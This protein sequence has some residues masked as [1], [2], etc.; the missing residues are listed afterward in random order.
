MKTHASIGAKILQSSD[1]P[2]LI[3]GEEIARCHHE[4]WDGR[5]YP[6]GLKGEEIPLA[7]RLMNIS[8]QYDALRS[9]RPYKPALDHEVVFDIIAK[10]DG[11][12]MPEHFDPRVLEAFS[13][14]AAKFRDV[15]ETHKEDIVATKW[16]Q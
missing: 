10:G 7:A 6:G 4:R 11:R 1:S 13:K 9:K 14:S 3:M 8:D 2:Y 15:Y 16:E 12:T 5:G